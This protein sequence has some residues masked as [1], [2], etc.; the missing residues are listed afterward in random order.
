MNGKMGKYFRRRGDVRRQT[1]P[2]LDE[3]LCIFVVPGL[4]QG[5]GGVQTQHRTRPRLWLICL[6][7]WPAQITVRSAP[8]YNS[9]LVQGV[10][11]FPRQ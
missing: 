2:Y 8:S 6:Y 10:P 7:P 1:C 5:P 4:V 3:P 11:S 9:Y